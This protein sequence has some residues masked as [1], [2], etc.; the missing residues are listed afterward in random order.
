MGFASEWLK[1]GAVFPEL[2]KEA[3]D[4]KTGIIVVVPAFDEPDITAL[5]GSLKS[6]VPSSCGC[7]V[8][9]VVNS[10]SD[11]GEQTILNNRVCVE[12]ANQWKDCN[13]T[14]FRLHIINIERAGIKG[15]GVGLARK[16]GMDEALRRFSRIGNPSGVIA[17]LDADCTVSPD[18]FTAVE[19]ELLLGPGRNACSICFEHPL[20]GGGHSPEIFTAIVQY[21]LHLRYYIEALRYAGF[22]YLFHTVGSTMAVRALSYMKAGGMNR[23]Q[24]GE[25]FYFVQKL[26]PAG[27]Y[28]NLNSTTVF[29]S[30]RISARVPFGTGA[31]VGKMIKNGESILYTYNPGSFGDLKELFS[32]S[33]LFYDKAGHTTANLHKA[34][35]PPIRSFVTQEEYASKLEEIRTNTSSVDAFGKRFFSW[36]NMFRVVKFLNYSHNEAYRKVPVFEAAVDLMKRTGIET[37]GL[38]PERLLMFLRLL[39]K[40]Q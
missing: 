29:P 26:V 27:G 39:Q 3:P 37:D 6:C 35:P 12:K 28:F 16:A 34:L 40:S 1:S 5:L 24:A 36:F 2:I 25:D 9:I 30:P 33:L 15:W 20:A 11:A 22:P 23:R 8:I 19:K 21:E 18:Y 4:N 7:E 14:F 17:C 10:S 13:D 31:A 32:L 38:S